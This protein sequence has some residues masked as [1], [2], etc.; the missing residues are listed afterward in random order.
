MTRHHLSAF[1]IVLAFGVLG[2]LLV[3]SR[4]EPRYDRRTVNEWEATRI[5]Q[6]QRECL[7][8]PTSHWDCG[9]VPR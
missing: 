6:W 9:E 8:D 5:A 2:A 3:S 1:A 7:D 4:S